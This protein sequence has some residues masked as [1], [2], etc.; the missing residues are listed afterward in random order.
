LLFSIKNALNRLAD[1]QAINIDVQNKDTVKNNF[2]LELIKS[3]AKG[4]VNIILSPKLMTIYAINYQ[5]LYGQNTT[6]DGPIDFIKKNKNLIK[7]LGKTILEFVIKLLL[8]LII[9]YLSKKLSQKY[10]KDEIERGKNYVSQILS[11]IG[12]PPEIIR[13]IQNISYVS[14]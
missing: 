9:K 1:L 7:A 8:T 3:L 14:V 5:I 6:Y 10:A 13:Q 12:T 4:I 11:L 2:I